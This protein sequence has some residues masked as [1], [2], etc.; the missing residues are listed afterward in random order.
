M[1]YREMSC[2]IDRQEGRERRVQSEKAI[3]IE[4]AFLRLAAIRAR[5]RDILAQLIQ[6][7]VAM[8]SDDGESIR[9]AALE[10]TDQYLTA[11]TRLRTIDRSA[12]KRGTQCG[13]QADTGD[14]DAA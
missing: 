13:H 11:F 5:N 10:E 2:L 3:Q 6:V 14:S 12:Q 4:R 9:R 1:N 7:G 8:R